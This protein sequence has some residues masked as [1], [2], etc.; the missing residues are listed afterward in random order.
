MHRLRCYALKVGTPSKKAVTARIKQL[1]A[2]GHIRIAVRHIEVD[3]IWREIRLAHVEQVILVGHVQ[4]FAGQT[5]KYRGKD[6][7]GRLIELLCY[8]KDES[9]LETLVVEEATTGHANTAY[10]P[11]SDDQELIDEWLSDNPDYKQVGPKKVQR[12]LEK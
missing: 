7:D 8:L 4:S 5:I 11:G 6:A 2:E 9:G 3:R 12:K 10:V 1:F